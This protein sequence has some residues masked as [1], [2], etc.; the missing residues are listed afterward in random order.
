[1]KKS[2]F[3][4]GAPP[5]GIKEKLIPKLKIDLIGKNE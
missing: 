5:I 2:R 4:I 3:K 1:M